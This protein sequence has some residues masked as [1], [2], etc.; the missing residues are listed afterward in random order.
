GLT[1]GQLHRLAGPGEGQKHVDAWLEAQVEA[2]RVVHRATPAGSAAIGRGQRYALRADVAEPMVRRLAEEGTLEEVVARGR[3]LFGA[4]AFGEVTLA[5][6]RGDL[7][8]VDRQLA[9][10]AKLAPAGAEA[11]LRESVCGAF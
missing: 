7:A 5:L 10:R 11:W 9:H 6:Q 2:G 3:A 1:R 8:A 4:R